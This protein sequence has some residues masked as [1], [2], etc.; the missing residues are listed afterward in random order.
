MNY[1]PPNVSGWTLSL[2]W[3]WQERGYMLG[4]RVSTVRVEVWRSNEE[5]Q[6]VVKRRFG[7][8]LQWYS[9]LKENVAYLIQEQ[10]ITPH[11]TKGR[12]RL[13]EE[14]ENEPSRNP[15]RIK[16][17]TL[18]LSPL[19]QLPTKTPTKENEPDVNRN[20]SKEDVTLEL[21]SFKSGTAMPI[22][23]LRRSCPACFG[24]SKPDLKHSK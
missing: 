7:C 15:K 13:R 10:I 8:A 5:L 4:K 23:H 21:T 9:F 17:V 2:E 22:E 20:T 16:K 19:K 1:L 18:E 11:R 14:V 24:G 3:F 12:K 6:E